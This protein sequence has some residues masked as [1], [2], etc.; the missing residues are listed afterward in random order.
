MKKVLLFLALLVVCKVGFG[1][2]D[3]D[4][5]TKQAGSWFTSSN[6]EIYQDGLGWV[7]ASTSPRNV[8]NNTVT[9]NHNMLMSSSNASLSTL[10]VLSGNLTIYSGREL[11]ISTTLTLNSGSIINVDGTLRIYSSFSNNVYINIG[12]ATVGS[13]GRLEIFG[14]FVNYGTCII[15]NKLN[16]DRGTFS[17]SG[18]TLTYGSG[19]TLIY[20]AETKTTG[21]E[22]LA[23]MSALP[24]TLE[25]NL[26]S[27]VDTLKLG[28]AAPTSIPFLVLTKGEFISDLTV[29]NKLT[30]NEGTAIGM[31]TYSAYLASLEYTGSSKTI[32]NEFPATNGPN[33]LTINLSSST[34]TISFGASDRTITGNVTLSLGNLNTNSN[35]LV[36][37]DYSSFTRMEGTFVGTVEYTSTSTLQYKGSSK[38]I[39]NEFPTSGYLSPNTPPNLT[40]NLDNNSILTINADRNIVGTLTLTNGILYNKDYTFTLGSGVSNSGTLGITNGKIIGTFKRWIAGGTST[41]TNG[42]P[43]ASWNSPYDLRSVNMTFTGSGVSGGTVSV[44]FVPENPGGN[45]IAPYDNSSAKLFDTYWTGGYW[46]IENGDGFTCTSYSTDFNTTGISGISKPDSIRVMKKALLTD[47]W[48]SPM[49]GTHVP[50]TNSLARRSGFTSFSIFGLAGSLIDLNPL[51]GL[52]PV[53]LASFNFNVSSNNVNLKWITSTEI[54]NKGFDVERKILN[55]NYEKIGYISGNGTTNNPITYSFAD[56]NLNAG[57]FQYRL[58]Q[59]DYNGNYEYHNLNNVVEIGVPGKFNL[60]QNYPNP[61]NPTTKIDFE[62]PKDSKIKLVIYDVT[63]KEVQTLVNDNRAAGYYTIDFNASNL[64]S[65]IYF[66][67]LLAD[68]TPLAI[69]KMALIK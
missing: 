67:Q 61:F 5:R 4:F 40:V 49:L 6:W 1:Q 19:A 60:S 27:D 26:G 66:Y 62:V 63:G 45:T 57:K 7:V 46:K 38:T 13:A 8:S 12:T 25:V 65:G 37:T 53:T 21:D 39:G 22:F 51:D 43:V 11:D 33:D 58:K 20:S 3:G 59:I 29:T 2:V 23:S 47:Q 34:N 15:N 64:S 18:G 24:S 36:L 41:P 55:G 42:W 17:N 31:I 14:T 68:N 35:K 54:N 16:I 48:V 44:T 50:G 69:K 30:R 52:N 56:K 28:L 32:G 10:L 9:I